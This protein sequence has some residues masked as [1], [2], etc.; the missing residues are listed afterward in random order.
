M[1]LAI[2]KNQLMVQIL[3]K[4]PVSH[5]KNGVK[6]ILLHLLVNVDQGVP[7]VL[8]DHQFADNVVNLTDVQITIT[9]RP[10]GDGAVDRLKDGRPS[11]LWR[12]FLAQFTDNF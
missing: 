5:L 9:L 7:L 10:P 12:K 11:I 6:V 2:H 1:K 8:V 3:Y 4:N